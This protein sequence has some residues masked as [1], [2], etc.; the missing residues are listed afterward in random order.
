LLQL[1]VLNLLATLFSIILLT[2]IISCVWY[3][4]GTLSFERSDG[5]VI[6]GWVS[7]NDTDLEFYL[8]GDSED[9]TYRYL[10]SMYTVF[11]GKFAF[12]AWEHFFGMIAQLAIGFI[13]GA[14]A[15]LMSTVVATDAAAQQ[16]IQS[17]LTAVKVR[18][19]TFY[20][21]QHAQTQ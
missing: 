8:L 2:H 17:K 13:F 16:E 3:L 18:H 14:L 6:S 21:P 7:N 4:L 19:A 15:S 10:V 12:T 20:W 5:I 1:Q 11:F 9:L